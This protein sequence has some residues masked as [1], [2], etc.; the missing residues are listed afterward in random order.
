[1][2]SL[3][4][5]VLGWVLAVAGAAFFVYGI[6]HVARGGSCASGGSY[7]S[8]KQCAPDS[9]AWMFAL[10]VAVLVALVGFWLVSR[11]G[12][13]SGSAPAATPAST[14][15]GNTAYGSTTFVQDPPVT[16]FAQQ[17]P[18]NGGQAALIE[19]LLANGAQLYTATSTAQPAQDPVA[20]LE[21][22]QALRASGA[23]SEEEFER[24]KAR[25]L[26]QM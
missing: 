26:A 7:V 21:K 9:T 24:A 3:V 4:R 18:A 1:M 20:Q 17:M 15:Y 11:R 25:V 6:Y 13:G 16:T 5:T 8:T 10:P 22:L 23:L 19:A 2:K 14:A 12:R